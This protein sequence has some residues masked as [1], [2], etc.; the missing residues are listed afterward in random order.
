MRAVV[1]RVTAASV[2]WDGGETSIGPGY[3]LLIGV[4]ETDQERDDQHHVAVAAIQ[5]GNGLDGWMHHCAADDKR[6]RVTFVMDNA[7]AERE[8]DVGWVNE[9]LLSASDA[10]IDW[11]RMCD[12]GFDCGGQLRSVGGR[13]DFVILQL[14]LLRAELLFEIL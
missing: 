9:G 12:G 11:L 3:C 4:A 1:Q 14:H 5:R 7:L 10:E 8:L 6:Q 13:D 2:R